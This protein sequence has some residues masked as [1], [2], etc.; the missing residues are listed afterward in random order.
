MWR[1]SDTY[2]QE[3]KGQ[4]SKVAL[5]PK[6]V[7][8]TVSKR[9]VPA[10][11]EEVFFRNQNI[12]GTLI[13]KEALR[14][15]SMLSYRKKTEK[16]MS[17]SERL[18]LET[19]MSFS[20]EARSNKGVALGRHIFGSVG[21]IEKI[22]VVTEWRLIVLTELGDLYTVFVEGANYESYSPTTLL[23]DFPLD[24]TDVNSKV[25]EKALFR[26]NSLQMYRLTG[27]VWKG[28]VIGRS[29]QFKTNPPVLQ[30]SPSKHMGVCVGVQIPGALTNGLVTSVCQVSD[31][32]A[33]AV[34]ESGAI[35]FILAVK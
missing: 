21:R 29:G 8:R 26:H 31:E 25:F 14:P 30:I 15:V 7:P 32:Q 17:N 28:P 18:K 9:A 22:F 20:C 6:T 33:I 34:T 27:E 23:V 12:V 3:K 35:Y 1:D 5:E 10:L 19:G 11:P 16:G 4:T 13:P 2:L 24:N